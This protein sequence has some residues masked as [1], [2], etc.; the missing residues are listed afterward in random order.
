MALW[1]GANKHDCGH[2]LRR[3]YSDVN[4]IIFNGIFSWERVYSNGSQIVSRGPL[5][6]LEP[7]S[8][9]P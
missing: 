4:L 8:G 9:G 2:N 6:G 1:E 7:I 5:V 3:V